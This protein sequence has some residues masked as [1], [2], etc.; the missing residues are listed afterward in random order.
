MK[1]MDHP[2]VI[3]FLDC[4]REKESFLMY[5]VMENYAGGSVDRL[6]GAN[7]MREVHV[8]CIMKQFLG[9]LRY[10]HQH[11]IVH[12]DIKP[13][14]LLYRL[15]GE[16]A[17]TDFGLSIYMANIQDHY[18]KVAGTPGYIAPEVVAGR[19]YGVKVRIT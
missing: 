10:I 6:V 13:Q 18:C 2:N 12:R 16:V 19:R 11:G 7:S 1:R 17:I 5:I 9:G 3:R 15:N 4:Y 14:N 8:A